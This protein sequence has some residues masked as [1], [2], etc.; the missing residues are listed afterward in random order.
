[1]RVFDVYLVSPQSHIFIRENKGNDSRVKEYE[2]GNDYKD[3]VV[4][5]ITAT[6]YPMFPSVLELEIQ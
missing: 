1:M 4:S 6:S 3:R 2:G 5:R